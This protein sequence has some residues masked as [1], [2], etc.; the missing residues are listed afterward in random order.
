MMIHRSKAWIALVLLLAWA[1]GSTVAAQLIVAHRGASHDAPEN[2]LA[3]FRLAWKQGADGIEGDFRLSRDGRIVCIHDEDTKR[4]AGKKLNV[5]KST[6]AEL[7]E[8][9]VGRWKDPKYAGER[10]AT[11]EEVIAIVPE[12]KWFFIELKAGSEIVK[13][14][15]KILAESSLDRDRVVIISFN[16]D[17]LAAC[18]KHLPRW[19]THWLSKHKQHAVSR[20]WG[21]IAAD[22]IKTI[23]E[24]RTDGFGSQANIKVFDDRYVRDL[25]EAG[26]PIFHVWTVDDADTARYYQGLGAFGITTNRPKL[27][28]D[29]LSKSRQ[30]EEDR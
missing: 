29:A 2:T 4:V 18:E 13:P 30:N 21:P 8:L 22:A 10:I 12:G 15:Q 14:L 19:S 28:R 20:R 9:D 17:T 7:R 6:L 27:I 23:K 11:L 1:H 24:V 25:R 26:I 5:A 3:A 16:K